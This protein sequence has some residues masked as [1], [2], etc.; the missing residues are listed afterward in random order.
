MN[1][2]V[3]FSLIVAYLQ[4][5]PEKC[6]FLP[7][8]SLYIQPSDY[9]LLVCLFKQ[10]YNIVLS[11]SV[12]SNS[13]RSHGLQPTRLLCPWG[14]SRQ[15]YQSGLPCPPAGDPPNPGIEPR[16][17]TLQVDSLLSEP[18]RKC[19]NSEVGS[20]SLLQGIVPTQE[21]NWGLLHCRWILYQLSYQESLFKQYLTP[22]FFLNPFNVFPVPLLD[23]L[24][25]YLFPP[26]FTSIICLFTW[27]FPVYTKLKLLHNYHY[28]STCFSYLSSS[29]PAPSLLF[30][31]EHSSDFTLIISESEIPSMIHAG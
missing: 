11:C 26:D 18:L 17:P 7:Q 10:Q 21:S 24:S 29:T 2:V 22:P 13:L 5:Q 19:K 25:C 8:F 28:Y 9:M 30:I 20:L 6:P 15:V 3:Q 1:T 4:Q 16:S 23:V 27:A 31:L 14:F 12:M